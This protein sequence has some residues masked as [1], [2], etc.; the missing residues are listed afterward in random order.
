MELDSRV[1][2]I[3]TII[4]I[5][6]ISMIHTLPL[7]AGCFFVVFILMLRMKLN[8][9]VMMKRLLVILPLLIAM[10]VMIPFTTLGDPAFS[11]FFFT[12][13]WQG[14]RLALALCLRTLTCIFVAVILTETTTLKKILEGMQYLGMPDVMIRIIELVLRYFMCIYQEYRKM[15]LGHRARA[16][17]Q[18]SS[19]WNLQT[20]QT[21]ASSTGNLF[22][23]SI[24]RSER[25]YM[26]MKSRGYGNE[27][28]TSNKPL[29]KKIDWYAIV[30]SCLVVMGLL[31]LD[32]GG[33]VQ[34]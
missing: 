31:F 21:I 20:L 24:D 19:M 33:F 34:W 7:L 30:F 26:A 25:I 6:G 28:L 1:K 2:I 8:V 13:T 22:M 14:I 15:T 29:L 23:R 5:S 3:M 17:Q 4:F 12:A 11:M 18:G 27:G 10:A 9:K 16:F 32:K